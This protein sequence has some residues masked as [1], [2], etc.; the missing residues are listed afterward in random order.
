MFIGGEESDEANQH[1]GM[2]G[3]KEAMMVKGQF[4]PKWAKIQN[5]VSFLLKNNNKDTDYK[6]T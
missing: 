4:R 1:M 3:R 6:Y 5:V 2:I